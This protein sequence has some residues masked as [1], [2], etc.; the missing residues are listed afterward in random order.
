MILGQ[1]GWNDDA[2]ITSADTQG[3]QMKCHFDIT[4]SNTDNSAER[5]QYIYFL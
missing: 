2:I 3:P 1:S 5:L 4:D